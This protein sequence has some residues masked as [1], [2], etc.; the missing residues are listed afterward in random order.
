MS[1]EIPTTLSNISSGERYPCALPRLSGRF[2][3]SNDCPKS[4]ASL[5][6]HKF[7]GHVVE[8]NG[9]DEAFVSA[10]VSR[11]FAGTTHN[12]FH[13]LRL[14]KFL[15]HSLFRKTINTDDFKMYM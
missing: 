11:R 8:P 12:H 13:C 5:I 9:V 7:V 3:T 1:H 4:D 14:T 2:D 10:W 15:D 6:R